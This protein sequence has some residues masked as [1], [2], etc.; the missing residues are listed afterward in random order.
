M[1]L[2]RYRSP[3]T[4]SSRPAVFMSLPPVSPHSPKRTK[5]R[6]ERP[7]KKQ[8]AETKIEMKVLE[9]VSQK[10]K[11]EPATPSKIFLNTRSFSSRQLRSNSTSKTSPTTPNKRTSTKRT[12]TKSTPP[13]RK[14]RTSRKSLQKNTRFVEPV[15]FPAWVAGEAYC[16]RS[17]ASPMA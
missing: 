1:T 6:T 10:I 15:R 8:E 14:T 11:L 16:L 5:A 7:G 9:M 2:L 4:R 3:V 12:S 17:R 13:K